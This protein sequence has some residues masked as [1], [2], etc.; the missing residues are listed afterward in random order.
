MPDAAHAEEQTW[1][2]TDQHV[3]LAEVVG[4]TNLKD[5]QRGTKHCQTSAAPDPRGDA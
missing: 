3:V 2:L 5:S 4:L 1:K